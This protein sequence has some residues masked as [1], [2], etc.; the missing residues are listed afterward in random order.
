MYSDFLYAFSNKMK[1][2][3][4]SMPS[5]V[6]SKVSSKSHKHR[7]EKNGEMKSSFTTQQFF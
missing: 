1:E 7:A 2:K 5:I 4:I 3:D 6:Q